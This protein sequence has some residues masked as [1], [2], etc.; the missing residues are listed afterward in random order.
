MNRTYFWLFWFLV[1][2]RKAAAGNS[3]ANFASKVFYVYFAWGII[4]F[5]VY[6]LFIVFVWNIAKTRLKMINIMCP[7]LVCCRTFLEI[8]SFVFY[9]WYTA[10]WTEVLVRKLRITWIVFWKSIW[11]YWRQTDLLF[12]DQTSLT[13]LEKVQIVQIKLNFRA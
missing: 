12:F 8:L 5:R 13:F 2:I 7:G 4:N 9:P 1:K 6:R 11:I 3:T 10:F